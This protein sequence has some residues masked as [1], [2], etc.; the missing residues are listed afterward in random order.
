M[1]RYNA[2]SMT[3]EMYTNVEIQQRNDFIYCVIMKYYKFLG[4]RTN[5]T[6]SP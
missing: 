5:D 6:T 1:H 4:E 3:L 2:S